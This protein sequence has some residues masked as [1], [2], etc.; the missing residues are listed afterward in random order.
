MFSGKIHYIEMV[1]FHC[2]VT[3]YQKIS[4]GY[5]RIATFGVDFY[6]AILW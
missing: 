5:F 4:D 1:I 6:S 2:D 3:N